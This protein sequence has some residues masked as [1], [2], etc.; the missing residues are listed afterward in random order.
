MPASSCDLNQFFERRQWGLDVFWIVK[1]R[2]VGPLT[3]IIR[4]LMLAIFLTFHLSDPKST[5]GSFAKREH[6]TSFIQNNS[7]VITTG[8][9]DCFVVKT[10][11]DNPSDWNAR[12]VV[13]AVSIE[14]AF[15][16]SQLSISPR[17]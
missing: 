12:R 6:L 14:V 2:T 17:P 9:L 10:K 11:L 5:I 3:V 8:D 7:E 15:N 1:R 13:K 4:S 16:Y